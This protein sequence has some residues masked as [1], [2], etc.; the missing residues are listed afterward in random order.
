MPQASIGLVDPNAAAEV[1]F[2]T[3]MAHTDDRDIL[4]SHSLDF[5]ETKSRRVDTPPAPASFGDVELFHSMLIHQ[6]T[7]IDPRV[8]E[9]EIAYYG[10]VLIRDKNDVRLFNP[11]PK[12]MSS[13]DLTIYPML[14][15]LI[16]ICSIY[17]W[18][19]REFS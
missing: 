4:D 10:K 14:T 12:D 18:A 1:V 13:S 11:A 2:D 15:K 3:G 7:T 8:C 9:W 16:K 17:N 6:A 5:N 19:K